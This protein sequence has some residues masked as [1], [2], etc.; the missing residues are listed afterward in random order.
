MAKHFTHVLACM[1]VLA[2][3]CSL[4][5][6]VTSSGTLCPPSW[7]GDSYFMT[8]GIRCFED[9]IEG[10]CLDASGR[11]LALEECASCEI[12]V[13]DCQ[14][15]QDARE[16]F[17][18][19]VL[20]PDK[21]AI[22]K[23][24]DD[25]DLSPY[26]SLMYKGKLLQCPDN[27]PRC[28]WSQHADGAIDEFKCV[29]CETDICG[30][31]CVN[32]DKDSMNCGGCGIKCDPTRDCQMG[33]CV[34]REKSILCDGICI[35][36]KSDPLHCGA[37][38]DCMGVHAGKICSEG[39]K[40]VEGACTRIGTR[41]EC[42]AD[43]HYL[44]DGSCEPDSVSHCGS[45]TLDC[46]KIA[47]W[48]DGVCEQKQPT[49]SEAEP[50]QGQKEMVCVV[51]SC[52]TGYHFVGSGQT[53]HC[54]RDT[55]AACGSRA[56]SCAQTEK[57]RE[58][59]CVDLCDAPEVLC[60]SWANGE[61]SYQCANPMD[62]L[63]HC[64]GCGNLCSTEVIPHSTGVSCEAG[65][66]RVVSCEADYHID[67]NRCVPD[68]VSN[69][70]ATGNSCHKI[71]EGWSDGTCEN[72]K[73]KLRK[74][75]SG[76]E[77]IVSNDGTVSC[78]RY[79]NHY[80]PM[81]DGGTCEDN[82]VCTYV[83]R[84]FVPGIGMGETSGWQCHSQ[85]NAGI[86]SI[87]SLVEKCEIGTDEWGCVD[88]TQDVNHCGAC[89][90]RCSDI[91]NSASVSCARV[92][93]TNALSPGVSAVTFSGRCKVL[94]CEPGY[95]VYER[96]AQEPL[97]SLCEADSLE[98]CGSH[99]NAC[100]V[101]NADNA[102][103]DGQC[104]ATCQIGY[105]MEGFSGCVEDT[106]ESCG[107][108]QTDCTG[109][110]GW[111]DGNCVA[112]EC[113]ATAC[114]EKYHLEEGEC[115]LDTN[116]V[117]GQ[118]RVKCGDGEVCSLGECQMSCGDGETECR[119]DAG[120]ACIDIQTDE[121][122]CGACGKICKTADIP[123]S[124]RVG[125]REGECVALACHDWAH[126]DGNGGCEL[127]NR[128]F[129]GSDSG[130]ECEVVHGETYCVNKSCT[131]ISCASG[132]HKTRD[133][134]CEPDDNVNCGTTGNS[135]VVANANYNC[136]NG[137]CMFLCEGGY[138]K[139]LGACEKDT[140][141]YCG[142][143]GMICE[144]TVENSTPIC[145]WNSAV[146]I[147]ECSYQCREGYYASSDACLPNNDDNC[148]GKNRKCTSPNNGVSKCNVESG[149]CVVTCNAGYQLSGSSCV[150]E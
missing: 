54:E 134:R 95:H 88:L 113:L 102:C 29:A 127:D 59:K 133:E 115:V 47:G 37:S 10:E 140:A 128:N 105:H 118:G 60:V 17:S 20:S 94:S 15:L 112:G 104:V 117:C 42:K 16:L 143:N 21:R 132:Y 124:T 7:S 139:S 144:P 66:C 28:V 82:E 138:H 76:F 46:T 32:F 92:S 108:S 97:E 23:V 142:E 50:R 83:T 89:H 130:P 75:A 12:E 77:K 33:S 44:E 4:D 136:N 91:P 129:C 40:C 67:D 85:C 1:V 52:Q 135:C 147:A 31:E 2:S 25:T 63:E 39:L 35:D 24:E 38:E 41:E 80:C 57:C 120:R 87:F 18:P 56:E 62:S 13:R 53:A 93:V 48:L 99:G 125:C 126:D 116:D 64:G 86:S 45:A 122:N 146:G 3:G 49:D 96:G 107:L 58:G 55:D 109:L 81:V 98:N 27:A 70:G 8:G 30:D 149:K 123:F 74:C 11:C 36:P 19:D 79:T 110:L 68:S 6:V 148:G 26:A 106:P 72:G 111:N 9:R 71:V 51:T 131:L 78:R 90:Q 141:E 101:E 150:A 145:R 43:E 121:R 34:C 69:C 114:A 100:N 137:V 119:D 73:C 65:N 84:V 103:V 22:S 14:R 5:A 61:S